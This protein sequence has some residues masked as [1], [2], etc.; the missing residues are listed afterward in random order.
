[1]SFDVISEFGPW[2]FGNTATV[3]LTESQTAMVTVSTNVY[4]DTGT[5]DRYLYL[6]LC[7]APVGSPTSLSTFSTYNRVNFTA[8]TVANQP[9]AISAIFE[10]PSA[11][12]YLVGPCAII[13]LSTTNTYRWHQSSGWIQ[14][15]N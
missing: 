10:P 5:Q 7:Y 1:M 9:S 15:S 12:T 14:V 8:A 4:R 3:T 6:A 11:G 2:I 13:P